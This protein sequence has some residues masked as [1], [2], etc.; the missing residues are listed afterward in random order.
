[1]KSN[2]ELEQLRGFS[3]AVLEELGVSLSAEALEPIRA[4][5]SLRGLREAARDM[6]EMCQDIN[7][8]QLVALDAR[9]ARAGLPTL[10]LM[11]DHRYRAFSAVLV[12]GRIDSD[13]EFRLVNSFVSD[14]EVG[15]LSEEARATATVLLGRYESDQ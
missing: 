4:S 15:Q 11:R 3:L 6:V 2:D 12:R 14:V 10:S 13:D 8:D 9:L 1:M 5:R 7:G